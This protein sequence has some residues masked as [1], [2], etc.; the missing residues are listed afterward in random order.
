MR[1]L[2]VAGVV[3]AASALFP[4]SALADAPLRVSFH[5]GGSLTLA[6]Q[7]ASRCLGSEG[8]FQFTDTT[9]SDHGKSTVFAQSSNQTQQVRLHGT[10]R[11]AVWTSTGSQD[12]P[13][14]YDGPPIELRL[15]DLVTPLSGFDPPQGYVSRLVTIDL[16]PVA[17][18]PSVSVT[19]DIQL[20]VAWLADGTISV[21]GGSGLLNCA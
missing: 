20:W 21:V 3:L 11:L 13:H 17:G 14:V 15:N 10:Y 16:V 9:I 1:R 19:W 12:D 18:G 8:T 4:S 2:V 6:F 7:P 5:G